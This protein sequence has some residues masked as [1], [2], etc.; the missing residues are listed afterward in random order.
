MNVL[1]RVAAGVL[2]AAAAGPAAAQYP[3]AMPPEPLPMGT[4]YYY[5]P[6]NPYWFRPAWPVPSYYPFGATNPVFGRYSWDS[7]VY[8]PAGPGWYQPNLPRYPQT[9]SYPTLPGRVWYGFGW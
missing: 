4:P 6:G 8:Y 5:Q 3:A 9:F 1:T 7:G 2:L